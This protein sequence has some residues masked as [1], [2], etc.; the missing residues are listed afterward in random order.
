[1]SLALSCCLTPLT[2][3]T[4]VLRPV[5]W[6]L[7]GVL[8]NRGVEFQ[9]GIVEKHCVTHGDVAAVGGVAADWQTHALLPQVAHKELQTDEGKDAE[10][11]HGEDHDI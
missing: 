3:I 2:I 5:E 10:A 8:Q 1:M 7:S 4:A 11:E 6:D 9:Q